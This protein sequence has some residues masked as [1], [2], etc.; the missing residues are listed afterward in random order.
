MIDGHY[1]SHADKLWES[2]AAPLVWLRVTPNQVTLAGLVGVA[3]AC[4]YYVS[5]QDSF[6]FGVVLALV[7]AGDAL[8]GAV[9]RLTDST[10]RYG[11]YLDAFVDRYQEIFVFAAIAE[12]HDAWFLAFVAITGSMLVS[13]AKA[14]AAMEIP[15]ANDDWPD[16]LER[17]ER[18]ILLVAALILEGLFPGHGVLL[19][20]VTLLAVLVHVTAV[21]RFLR[22]RGRILRREG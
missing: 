14:R 22:A 16:L 7:L 13:Y 6:R 5:V 21:Q 3:L 12:V 17:T 19:G 18:V 4:G 1:K 11:G 15:V 20:A 9:A 10:S 8:D 2:L